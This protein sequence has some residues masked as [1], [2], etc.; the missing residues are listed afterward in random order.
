MKKILTMIAM[1][2]SML[3]ILLA[4]NLATGYGEPAP[5]AAGGQGQNIWDR[6]AVF[7]GGGLS[8][9]YSFS[10][11]IGG[12]IAVVADDRLTV[13]GIGHAG[14]VHVY[15]RNEATGGWVAVKVLT[16]PD[17]HQCGHFGAAVAVTESADTIIVGENG[18][19]D[20]PACKQDGSIYFFGRDEGGLDN[21]GLFKVVDGAGAYGKPFRVDGDTLVVGIP[22]DTWDGGCD[23]GGELRP[24]FI[25]GSV[26]IFKRDAGGFDNWGMVKEIEPPALDDYDKHFGCSVAI[27]GDRLAV[28]APDYGET[29]M[30]Y[31]YDGEQDWSLVESHTGFQQWN[32]FGFAV[33]VGAQGFFIAAPF[34][35]RGLGYDH[36]GQ[37]YP[38]GSSTGLP[39][40]LIDPTGDW[41]YIVGT[42]MALDG[43]FLAVSYNGTNETEVHDH[44]LIYR[45]TNLGWELVQ[46]I[47]D[48]GPECWSNMSIAMDGAKL[49]IGE[50]GCSGIG[51][52]HIFERTSGGEPN[53]AFLPIIIR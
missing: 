12:D 6:V 29:G 43:E 44:V 25:A 5:R 32:T 1:A 52:A 30:A 27:S 34:E 53:T 2:A 50:T 51:R 14:V 15:E 37:V 16:A 20:H 9:T 39:Y 31:L 21:W 13:D 41:G 3:S 4:A 47:E 10:V 33:A 7:S 38:A 48:I 36:V 11:D 19:R 45:N 49:I 8:T 26:Q 46:V 24:E 18:R 28:G 40:P 23:N 22:G 42:A 35:H 17:L